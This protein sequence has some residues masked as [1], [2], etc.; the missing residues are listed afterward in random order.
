MRLNRRRWWPCTLILIAMALVS[1]P[2]SAA[3]PPVAVFPVPGSH[4]AAPPTQITFRGIPA[5]ALGTIVVTGSRSGV[6]GG[7]VRS[8]SDGQGG[9]FLPTAAFAPGEVVTV[10][11]GLDVIGGANGGFQFTIAT[12]AGAIPPA[13]R[14]SAPR[15]PGDVNRFPSRPDLAPAA[16]K[17]ITRSSREAPGDIFVAPQVGPVQDG[18]M[19][20]G[21]SGG[22]VWFKPVPGQD[23]AS[24]FRVQSYHGAPV[25]TWWQGTVNAGVGN[26]QDEIYDTH[27]SRIAA[28]R[29][30][31]GL[32]SD[33]HEFQ[34]TATGTALI[35]AYYPVYVDASSVKHGPTRAI[36]LDSVVQEI[37]IPTGLVLFQWDSLDHVPLTE[38]EA[39]FPAGTRHPYDYF[40][41]NSI[42]QD[43]DGNLIVSGRNTWAAYKIDHTTGAVIWRLG[44]K[45]SSFRMGPGS[46]FAF[47]HDVRV[48]PGNLVT[49]FDDGAG[50][51][52]VH[53]QSRA[54]LLRIDPVGMTASL[55]FADGHRSG[56]LAQFEGNDQLLP[57]GDNMVGW[58]QQPYFTEY[59]AFGQTVFDA[60]F[61]DANTNYRAYRFPW[62]GTPLTLPAVAVTR[63]G[64]G[65][66]VYA[67]WNGATNVAAW[68]VLTGTSPSSLRRVGTVAKRAFEAI[69]TI[70]QR[71]PYA[72]IEALDSHGAVLASSKTAVVG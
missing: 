52:T 35:T 26:G 5:G 70:K 61:V 3:G 33:L 21:Q 27:Y 64:G 14:L 15:V 20:L 65:E 36:V 62:S 67:S 51:P 44:G 56:L 10:R 59:N 43:T 48:H 23:W 19:I 66:T 17:V 31:N 42:Q 38:S 63:S 50:P 47:Q 71:Q 53:N 60:R 22:L 7:S 39:T 16:V 45:R 18:V 69:I 25:L 2:A 24:D 4:F 6:H 13:N 8:D 28:V 29:G 72:A 46:Q 41:V 49:L 68:R 32:A 57:G 58:G 55:V 1:A 12:P 11:T 37:D 34:L 54:L 30:G 9:S 40:H